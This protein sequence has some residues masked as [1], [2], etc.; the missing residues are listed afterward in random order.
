IS[1][2]VKYAAGAPIQISLSST[3]GEARISVRDRGMGIAPADQGRIFE[4]FERAVPLKN[5]GGL[6][7]GLYIARQIVELHHGSISVQSELGQGA[8]FLVRLPLDPAEAEQN[9]SRH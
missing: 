5:Y 7:L 3:D 1:N 4:R 8:T 9:Q 6:G 2:S